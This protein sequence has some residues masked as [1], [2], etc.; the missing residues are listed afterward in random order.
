MDGCGGGGGE[1]GREGGG[2]QWEDSLWEQRDLVKQQGN[3]KEFVQQENSNREAVS[4]WT[5]V[6]E[7][8]ML[9]HRVHQEITKFW[10]FRNNLE[11]LHRLCTVDD[12]LQK[13]G[14]A[15]YKI[16]GRI[17]HWSV[18][19]S[20]SSQKHSVL[21]VTSPV[22]MCPERLSEKTKWHRWRRHFVYHQRSP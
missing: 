21:L 22:S 10:T 5:L 20:K 7:K 8:P 19:N 4:S 3:A 16:R 13:S 12:F 17:R 14:T 15:E 9:Q 6:G 1:G 11:L 18:E 2:E